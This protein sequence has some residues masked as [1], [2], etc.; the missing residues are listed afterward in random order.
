MNRID[1][2]IRGLALK[3]EDFVMAGLVPAIH[4]EVRTT[5][6]SLGA[7]ERRETDWSFE[8][9]A[10]LHGVDARNKCG[11]DAGRVDQMPTPSAYAL[12]RG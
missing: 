8:T 9:T 1:R 2:P 3:D 4:A 6:S 10:A 7:V 5:G 11:H 12:S